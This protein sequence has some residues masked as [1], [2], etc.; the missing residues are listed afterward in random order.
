MNNR[1]APVVD[2]I[3][4]SSSS[5]GT[6]GTS[7]AVLGDLPRPYKDQR[8]SPL[9]LWHPGRHL[10][11]PG[12]A[13][14]RSRSPCW[15]RRARRTRQRAR[16]L[17]RQHPVHLA[18]SKKHRRAFAL[19]A[20]HH[21]R[22]P[23]Q[24]LMATAPW[25]C[26]CGRKNSYKAEFCQICGASWMWTFGGGAS[27][28][29]TSSWQRDWQDGP[30]T[31]RKRSQSRSRGKGKGGAK[32]G[33]TSKQG[34]KEAGYTGDGGAPWR[35][36]SS[37]LESMGITM[38]DTPTSK[39]PVAGQQKDGQNM[40]QV[41]S[42]LRSHLKSLGQEV[43]PEIESFLLQKTGNKAQAIRVASQKLE[44]SQRTSTKLQAEIT[45]QKV[46]W[47]KFQDK[48]SEEYEAQL[49]KYQERIAT[50]ND[51]LQKAG[52][53]YTEAKKILQEAANET[54]E[55]TEITHPPDLP[56][57]P[58]APPGKTAEPASDSGRTSMWFPTRS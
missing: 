29:S 36:S 37:L 10:Q 45:Q 17:L 55:N 24:I 25:T 4:A 20:R 13:P 15:H 52:E 57:A 30:K 50:L 31:P 16:R 3:V 53:D 7:V 39:T 18:P 1:S 58:A 22:S 12:T 6:L 21:T 5:W 40:E 23:P 14:S 42:G 41:L 33:K 8:G 19:L 32:N 54:E 38:P 35:Q 11:L 26:S 2:A 47:K 49:T 27:G 46:Q 56:A 9:P 34:G 44:A 48:I 43:S 28:A 51:A